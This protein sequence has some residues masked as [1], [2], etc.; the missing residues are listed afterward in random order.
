MLGAGQG[1]QAEKLMKRRKTYQ[2]QLDFVGVKDG[3]EC[4]VSCCVVLEQKTSEACK[5]DKVGRRAR[6]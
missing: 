2:M 3:P 6:W 4:G 1:A 5:V